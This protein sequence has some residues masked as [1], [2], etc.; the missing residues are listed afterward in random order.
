MAYSQQAAAAGGWPLEGCKMEA[1]CY[2]LFLTG[3]FSAAYGMWMTLAFQELTL[4]HRRLLQ[5]LHEN[6]FL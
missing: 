1:H 5:T 6:A 3:V 2:T 4:P